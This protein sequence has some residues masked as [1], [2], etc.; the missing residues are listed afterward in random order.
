MSNVETA[1][2]AKSL[3]HITKTAL[4]PLVKE[5]AERAERERRLPEPLAEAFTKAGIFRMARPSAFGGL[6]VDPV[7]TLQIIEALSAADGSAGWCAMISGA[8][9][10][11]ESYLSLEGGKQ[12]FKDG[13]VVTGGVIAPT[14]R[15]VPV[16]GG[17]RISGH[18]SVASNCHNCHWLGA[19]SVVFEGAAPKMAPHGMPEM[20]A[21]FLARADVEILD[22]WNV[23]GLRGTGSHD[24]TAS[25]VFV[26][27][28]RC[29]RIPFMEPIHQGKLFEFPF[30]G[31][32]AMSIA[33][34]ALGIARSAVNDFSRMARVKT[35]A[36]MMSTLATRA[37]AQ[38][39]AAEAEAT[40][41]S[42]RAYLLESVTELWASVNRGEK[43]T[44]VQR[45]NLRIAATH[46]TTSAARAVDLIY[47]AGGG[48][49]LYASN[50]L[51][52]AFRD[53]HAVTQHMSV[54]PATHEL[55][56]KLL[57]GVELDAPM[58]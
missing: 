24:F 16:E 52:R 7:T 38:L 31:F 27:T 51:Q 6:E 57:L 55:H 47:T 29:I 22:T 36:G 14:G 10:A 44:M 45:A 54:A 42:A 5:Y 18:W 48:S 43:P 56:G 37:S 50:P 28:A 13:N 30:F 33:S 49:A 32:L 40:L 4:V 9:G 1:T 11:F 17:Y 21:P 26:P 20:I 58:L 35:P 3:L 34:T 12:I 15:A 39:A 46:A 19:C 53:V 8:G 41:R 2:D 23:I 25:D